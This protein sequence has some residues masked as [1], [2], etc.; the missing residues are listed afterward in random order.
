MF[1]RRKWEG[2]RTE[3][4]SL[5]LHSLDF[6]LGSFRPV[7]KCYP[8]TCPSW[9]CF[10]RLPHISLQ[11]VLSHPAPLLSWHS[12]QQRY[13]GLSCFYCLHSPHWDFLLW[14]LP[15]GYLLCSLL[16]SRSNSACHVEGAWQTLSEQLGSIACAA[17]QL[18]VCFLP[19]M[20]IAVP[21]YPWRLGPGLPADTKVHG[22]SGYLHKVV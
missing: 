18:L 11:L 4:E 20:D 12:E 9:P 8:S 13:C 5:H 19:F 1:W 15:H 17:L 22:C 6:S 2:Y 7:F 21:W 16:S 10:P 3:E 14:S